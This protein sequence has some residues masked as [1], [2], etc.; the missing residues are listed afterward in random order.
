M[1][2]RSFITAVGAGALVAGAARAGALS[3]AAPVRVVAD[4]GLAESGAFAAEAARLGARISWTEA[5]VTRLWYEELDLLWRERK[6][7]LA[8]LTGPAAFFCLERLALDRG[9]RTVFKGEHRPG[10]D[11]ASH[12]LKG[13]AAVVAPRA[14]D[15]PS[16][17]AWPAQMARLALA[18]LGARP[19]FAPVAPF[20]PAAAEP[21]P[22]VSWALAP[23]RRAAA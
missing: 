22:L 14:L 17:R 16:G 11:G 18:S 20:A 13:S 8:G 1:H 12:E 10:A 7:P 3:A 9:L 19:P 15:G 23:A 6:V 4:R 2:R 5:D 21:P